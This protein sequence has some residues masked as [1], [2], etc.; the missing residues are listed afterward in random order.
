MNLSLGGLLVQWETLVTFHPQFALAILNGIG[1]RPSTRI[2]QAT[3]PSTT[4]N[5]EVPGSFDAV[6]TTYSVF[7]GIDIGIDPTNAFAGNPQK[8]QS[9]F[10]QAWGASGIRVQIQARTRGDNDYNPIPSDL[11]LQM[12]PSVLNKTAGAWKMI[13]PDNVKVLFTLAQLPP[14]GTAAAPLTVWMAWS[15]LCL[16]PGGEDYLSIDPVVARVRLA[17]MIAALTVVPVAVP[18]PAATGT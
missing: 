4:L 9:D 18:P 7:G 16:G 5:Q 14:G 3:F 12:V 11:P 13:N 15:F 1:V 2:V 6:I 17:A 8:A 10:F